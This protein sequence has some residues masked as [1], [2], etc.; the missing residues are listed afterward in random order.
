MVYSTLIC[1]SWSQKHRSSDPSSFPSTGT[2]CPFTS[3]APSTTQPRFSVFP[4][5]PAASLPTTANHSGC[6]C[7]AHPLASGAAR[8]GQQHQAQHPAGWDLPSAGGSPWPLLWNPSVTSSS[9]LQQGE[10]SLG[11]NRDKKRRHWKETPARRQR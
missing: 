4:P 6:R 8:S 1:I 5:Y 11:A 9:R 2:C 10:S 7:R 3:S